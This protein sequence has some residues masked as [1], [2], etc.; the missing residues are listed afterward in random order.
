MIQVYNWIG[1]R[2]MFFALLLTA[3]STVAW[4]IDK[5]SEHGW[6]S[7][8]EWSWGIYAF[9][10]LGSKVATQIRLRQERGAD[11]NAK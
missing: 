2:K 11:D 9:G 5:M 4:F 3:I 1:G 10:N 7:F 6:I 8:M